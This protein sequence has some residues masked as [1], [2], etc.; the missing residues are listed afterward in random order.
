MS[1]I[2]PTATIH[3][4]AIIEDNV[5]IGKN[6]TIGPYS[7]ISHSH[8]GDNN[9]IGS[10]CVIGSPPQDIHDSGENCYVKIGNNNTVRE[11]TTIHRGTSEGRQSTEI[12]DN[13]YFMVSSHIA[14]DCIVESNVILGNNVAL[15]G[16]VYVHKGATLNA[17]VAVAQHQYVGEYAFCVAQSI[18]QNSIPPFVVTDDRRAK[19][20]RVN[21]VGLSRAGIS[22]ESI[23]LIQWAYKKLKKEGRQDALQDIQAKFKETSL[24]ELNMIVEFYKNHKNIIRF[25]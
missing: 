15:A 23:K 12:A 3:S 10:H 18:S 24:D 2:D 20:L 11:F 21:T 22:A 6:T 8:I 1:C 25:I 16:Y 14:H 4:T 5:S 17:Y 13:C 7:V 9:I 19:I